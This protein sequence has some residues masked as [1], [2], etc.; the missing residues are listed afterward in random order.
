MSGFSDSEK[1]DLL[2]KKFFGKPSTNTSI[3][4]YQEAGLNARPSTISVF[5]LVALPKSIL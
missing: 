3:Q 2:I 1:I 4:F 5:K